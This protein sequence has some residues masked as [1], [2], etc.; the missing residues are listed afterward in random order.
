[1]NDKPREEQLQDLRNEVIFLAY[2]TLIGNNS[3]NG[4]CCS[5]LKA[6]LLKNCRAEQW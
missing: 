3:M 6:F 2:L 4:Q 5:F 1:M